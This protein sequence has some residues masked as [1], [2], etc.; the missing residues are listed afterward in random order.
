MMRTRQ[1]TH[2][3]IPG[4]TLI[5]LLSVIGIIALL[6][7]LVVPALAS[8]NKSRALNNAGGQFTNLLSAARAEAITRRTVVRVEVAITWP[9]PAFKYRKATLTS[10]TLNAAGDAYN[11]Q[12]IGKWQT[13]D[14][15]IVFAPKDPLNNAP[16]DGSVYL[17][18]SSGEVPLGD[19]GKL[20]FAGQD[21]TTAYIAFSPTGALLEQRPPTNLP[22]PIRVRLVEGL[23]NPAGTVTYTRSANWFDLRV[24]HLFG[25]VEIG[26]PENPLPTLTPAP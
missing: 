12:P 2:G 13:L 17:F 26:R 8:I 6:L 10:A 14:D 16:V 5:E 19:Q 9:D 18:D 20:S 25:R 24:N 4:F 3:Q 23:L 7:V 15:G 11:Y 1:P 21:V 22:V